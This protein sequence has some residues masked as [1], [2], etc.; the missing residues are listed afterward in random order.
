MRRVEFEESTRKRER[1]VEHLKRTT[2]YMVYRGGGSK[3]EGFRETGR[4]NH[5][6]KAAECNC[7]DLLH[8]LERN[9][10]AHDKLEET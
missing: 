8:S 4:E 1:T 10:L 3:K 2:R 9:T 7:H 5:L 6:K